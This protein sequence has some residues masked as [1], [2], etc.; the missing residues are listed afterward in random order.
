M[1]ENGMNNYNGKDGNGYQPLP[2]NDK[3]PEITQEGIDYIETKTNRICARIDQEIDKIPAN[4]SPIDYQSEIRKAMVKV[5]IEAIV[6]KRFR[7]E[8]E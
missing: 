6:R 7:K 2:D 4:L 1:R 5:I 3:D 8:D